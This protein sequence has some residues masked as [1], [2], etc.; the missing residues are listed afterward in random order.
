MADRTVFRGSPPNGL[1]AKLRPFWAQVYCGRPSE[2]VLLMVADVLRPS[3][4]I[5]AG[6]ATRD[7]TC[8]PP[9]R[10][11]VYPQNVERPPSTK[12]SIKQRMVQ[13]AFGPVHKSLHTTCLKITHRVLILA[14]GRSRG[15]TTHWTV[16]LENGRFPSALGGTVATV[17][18]GGGLPPLLSLALGC[19]AR[20]PLWDGAPDGSRC[21]PALTSHSRRPCHERPN[22][23]SPLY[24]A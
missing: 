12:G 19:A 22:L 7:P 8:H 17:G 15:H 14:T 10:G 9:L 18:G 21:P 24:G 11:L 6:L 4:V 5:H 13:N 3:Q 2:T 23:S 1:S 16:T 20:R